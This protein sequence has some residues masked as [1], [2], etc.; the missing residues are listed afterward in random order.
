MNQNLEPSRH[1]LPPLPSE[2]DPLLVHFSE[3]VTMP[4]AELNAVLENRVAS[5]APTF[6]SNIVQR[7]G[8]YISRTGQPNI[9]IARF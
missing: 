2:E 1:F 9:D 6:L 4:I 5:I 3:V 8:A 7:F